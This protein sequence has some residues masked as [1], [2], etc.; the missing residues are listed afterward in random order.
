MIKS[1]AANWWFRSQTEHRS[2][3]QTVPSPEGAVWLQHINHAN[4][5]YWLINKRSRGKQFTTSYMIHPPPG[6]KSQTS[7]DQT[8]LTD[9]CFLSPPS[10]SFGAAHTVNTVNYRMIHSQAHIYNREQCRIQTESKH[11][12]KSH[13][14]SY[15]NELHKLYG[16]FC[17]V[18]FCL[19]KKNGIYSYSV[20]WMS[21]Q[22]TSDHHQVLQRQI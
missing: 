16:V 22:Q 9:A 6:V 21:F 3:I 11:N 12:Y 2:Y 7:W 4:N 1:L 10:F 19:P 5:G 20:V 17:F 8:E 18:L 13:L 15:D 14:Q